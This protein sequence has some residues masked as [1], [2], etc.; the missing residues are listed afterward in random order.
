MIKT[1]ILQEV[2]LKM[3]K[4]KNKVL[5]YESKIYSI[6]HRKKCNIKVIFLHAV[7]LGLI[8]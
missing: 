5:K 8:S 7:G 3:C 4:N 6:G 1:L 2:R